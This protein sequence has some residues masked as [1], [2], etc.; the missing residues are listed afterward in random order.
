MAQNGRGGWSQQNTG[1]YPPLGYSYF[2][3]LEINRVGQALC[4][5]GTPESFHQWHRTPGSRRAVAG[6][7][8]SKGKERQWE[9]RKGSL[10]EEALSCQIILCRAL[11]LS[12][13]LGVRSHLPTLSSLHSPT[14]A[15]ILELTEPSMLLLGPFSVI[16]K[17]FLI[18]TFSAAEKA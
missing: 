2:P 17:H 9:G 15:V 16:L 6:S 4:G 13:K 14:C 8:K 10:V 7:S 12:L 3:S 1:P 5:D 11:S 18:A